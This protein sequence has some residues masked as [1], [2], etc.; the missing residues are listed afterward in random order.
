MQA[1]AKK[2]VRVIHSRAHAKQDAN[3]TFMAS[4]AASVLNDLWR[5]GK[6]VSCAEMRLS[7]SW[8]LFPYDEVSA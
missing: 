6:N 4:A 7:S 2:G 8:G 3:G 5:F 1:C